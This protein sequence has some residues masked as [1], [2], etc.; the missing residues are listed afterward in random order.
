MQLIDEQKESDKAKKRKLLEYL[1]KEGLVQD[2]DTGLIL[3]HLNDGGITK[4]AKHQ[5]VLK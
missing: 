5:D 1:K 4:V 2:K 3:I